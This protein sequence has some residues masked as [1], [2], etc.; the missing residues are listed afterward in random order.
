MQ[1][2][3][4]SDTWEAEA[5]LSPNQGLPGQLSEMLSQ[6]KKFKGVCVE[7]VLLGG[8]AKDPEFNLQH[9]RK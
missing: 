1:R 9:L 7:G 2:P 3:G 4:T 6:T 5:R 8:H